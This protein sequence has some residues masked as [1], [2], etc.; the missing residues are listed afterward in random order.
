M[1]MIDIYQSVSLI[2]HLLFVVFLF[3]IVFTR[4]KK[5]KVIKITKNAFL[6]SPKLNARK[7]KIC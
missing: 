5:P 6:V 2:Y 7:K 1:F 4:N 3:L